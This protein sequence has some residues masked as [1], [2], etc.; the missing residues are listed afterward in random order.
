MAS[1]IQIQG[2]HGRLVWVN[3]EHVSFIRAEDRKTKLYFENGQELVAE[4]S[5]AAVL[6]LFKSNGKVD[7][8]EQ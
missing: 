1:F 3:P 6:D 2:T 7:G 4:V 8:V 5:V